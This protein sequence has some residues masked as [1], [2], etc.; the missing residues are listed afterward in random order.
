MYLKL[1]KNEFQ[2]NRTGSVL[3]CIFMTLSVTIAVAVFFMLVNLFASISSMYE[4]ANPPHFLQMHKGTIHAEDIDAF[5][6]SYNGLEH[7]SG[8]QLQRAAICRAMS[9][10]PE[11]L[12][13]DEPTG[14]LNLSATKEVMDI[15]NKINGE[16]TTI[17][18]VTHDA[19]VAAR[20]DKVIYLEDGSIREICRL[21]KHKDS[22]IIVNVSLQN[23]MI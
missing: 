2:K 7:A 12:F 8:G 14:A 10:H 11:I 3:L 19:K 1:L 4:T 5:N 20:A 23:V 15:L 22:C 6:S 16:G 13:G 17:L 21:A 18:L 9:N